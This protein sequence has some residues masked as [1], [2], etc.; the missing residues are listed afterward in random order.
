MPD[1][2]TVSVP[3][4]DDESILTETPTVL[5]CGGDGGIEMGNA[6][7]DLAE[8]EGIAERVRMVA[9]NSGTEKFSDLDD[10]I[11]TVTLKTP[12][13]RFHDH[14][15]RNR[16]YLRDDITIDGGDGAGR[17]PCLGRYY[18]DNP[19]D[20]GSHEDKIRR[21]ISEFVERF[22]SDPDVSGP[23]AVNVFHLVGAG[24][25]TGSGIAPLVTGLLHEVLKDLDEE[26][27]PG[28]EHWAVC[29][30]ASTENF[31]GGGD[32][33]DVHWR[34]PANSLALLDELRAITDYDGETEYPLRIP[35]LA[36][37]DQANNRRSAYTITE[38]PFSGVFLLRYDQD[39]S[40]DAEYRE[41]VDRTAARVVVE[42]MRKGKGQ[43]Q[44]VDVENEAKALEHTFYEVRGAD[45]E[46]PVDEIEELLE[47]KRDYQAHDE[48]VEELSAEIEALDAARAQLDAA[49]DADD[50]LRGEGDLVAEGAENADG[51]DVTAV[52]EAMLTEFER[53]RQIAGNIDPHATRLDGIETELGEHQNRRTHTFHDRVDADRIQRAVFMAAMYRETA[54][55]LRSHRFRALV[56]QY[57]ERR[58]DEIEAFDPA[59]D[60]TDGAKTQFVQTIEPMLEDQIASLS[61]ELD[62]LGMSARITDRATYTNCKEDLE[63]TRENLQRLREAL[64]ERDRLASLAEDIAAERDDVI[65]TLEARRAALD[66]ARE[67]AVS[68]RKTATQ[69]RDAAKARMEEQIEA[70]R[71]APLGRF[72]TLPVASGVELDGERV[73]EDAGI[74]ALIDDGVMESERVATL[75]RETLDNHD[76]GVLGARLETRN[77]SRTP[78]RD[79]PVVFCT[80]AVRERIWQDG[81]AGNAPKT[82]AEDE[83][84]KQPRAVVCNDEQRIGLL[85]YHG[86]LALDDFDHGAL[87]AS[88]ERGQPTLWGAPIPLAEC[89]AYPELLP[90]SHPVSMRSQVENATLPEWGEDDD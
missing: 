17:D 35:L 25:G 82:V 6:V 26:V 87:R 31:D 81:A 42:W 67:T 13:R 37:R 21:A 79:H 66:D 58:G 56:D 8:R 57:V 18:F 88:L 33:P 89:Y 15:K 11:E 76:D 43:P 50:H 48:T 16:H 41:G 23:S 69:R 44:F 36:S 90:A 62:D 52:P 27:H 51:D 40:D 4:D 30:L 28:F 20:V 46:V 61:S 59:F 74:T 49:I 75:L 68:D 54:A 77:E 3:D 83:F 39:R 71:E 65:E 45:F 12:D 24:G 22:E 60:E 1:T 9:I 19:E 34:Y 70:V 47:N 78:S 64:E 85:A 80:Q 7:L 38:N 2:T 73:A 55:E 32:A 5:V 84:D 86:G 14:D 72:V 10:D 29:S 53:A 63:R